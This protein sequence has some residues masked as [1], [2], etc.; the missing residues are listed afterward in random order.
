M[1]FWILL[2]VCIVCDVWYG[3]IFYSITSDEDRRAT[4]STLSI[5]Q[6]T[7]TTVIGGL[8]IA[9]LFT[10]LIEISKKTT[11]SLN[12]CQIIFT[13]IAITC[14]VTTTWQIE[15]SKVGW[16]DIFFNIVS[17]LF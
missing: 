12:I 9:I 17:I 5:V 14:M 3:Y 7:I 2:T 6:G 11:E 15:V 4:L 1:I 13:I 8:N 16:N 10:L